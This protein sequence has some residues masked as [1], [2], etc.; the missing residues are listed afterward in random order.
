MK[1]RSI[2]LTFLVCLI[3]ASLCLAQ[4]ANMGTWKL[5]ESKSEIPAGVGKNTTV[6]YSEAGSDTKVTT[7]GVDAQ[8]KP[9]HTEWTG[10]FDSK[11][12]PLTGD[13]NADF[14]AYRTKG[15]RKLQFANMKG[16][17]TV[18]NGTIELAKDGKTRTV[19]VTFVG[20][21]KKKTKAKY[22]YDKQ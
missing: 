14:R 12:Y 16:N 1:I 10:K 17:A 7:D 6:V 4:N 8:G 5:E 19:T 22:V 18:S 21:N 11:P 13:P 2:V 9:A 20:A 3:A 15:E